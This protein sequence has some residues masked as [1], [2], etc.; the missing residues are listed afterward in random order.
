MSELDTIFALASAPGRAGVAVVRI[1]GPQARTAAERLGA[2]LPQ[3][4]RMD[5]VRLIDPIT[6]E[7]SPVLEGN[8][9]GRT[10]PGGGVI[11]HALAVSFPGPASFTGEDVVELHLHGGRAI[12]AAVMRALGTCEGLRPA[13]PGEFS[14]RAFLNGKMDL[15]EAEGLAD[16]IDAETRAQRDQ[17]LRQMAGGLSARLEP[18]RG[19]LIH[20]MAMLEAWIDFPDEEIPDSLVAETANDLAGLSGEMAALLD[21]ADRAERLREGLRIAIVGPP[22]AGKS[23]LLNALANREIAIVSDTAGTTRDS[24]EVNLDLAG[25]PVTIWD[26]AGLRES[27]DSVEQEGIRRALD[28]ARAAD[29]VL[30]IAEAG[31]GDGNPALEAVDLGALG[32]A[33]NVVLTIAS[34]VDL[35]GAV[36]DGSIPLSVR[37]ESGLQ[38]LVSR[39][40]S[41]AESRMGLSE[42]PSLS[43]E[44]HRHAV[45][46]ALAAVDRAREGLAAGL[47]TELV[48]ED[49]RHAAQSIGRVTGR[50][51]VDDLLDAIF[52]TF[53]LGK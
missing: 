35:G 9:P 23:S 45:A 50:V 38:A 27:T 53:C 40:S 16:L 12:L 22:N 51:D 17:A 34:K 4:R 44:R 19:R 6:G 21:G 37:S 31:S 42:A 52:G 32:V 28:R 7:N 48:A 14:R 18:L 49:L 39:L 13:D 1:S 30:L 20:A 46:A 29:L 10:N 8:D 47:E 43:R 25:Y 15:V 41:E 24:L 11:D 33:P 26:T 36:P 5:R 3:P 2:R